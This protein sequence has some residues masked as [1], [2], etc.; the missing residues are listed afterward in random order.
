MAYVPSPAVEPA[1]GGEATVVTVVAGAKEADPSVKIILHHHLGRSNERMRPWLDNLIQRGVQFDII[2]MSCYA[3]AQEGDWK[4]NFADL[5][6]R[7]P[8]KGLLVV[9]YSARKRFINDLMFD[10]PDKKGLGTFIWEPTRH[11]ESL[12]D[13]DGKSA[14]GG[15][16]SNF[17]T[18]EGI[19]QGARLRTNS[20]L[21]TNIMTSAVNPANA[22]ENTN[23][24]EFIYR[25]FGTNENARADWR[26]RRFGGRY[27]VN[28]LMDLYP[29]MSRDY[30][31]DKTGQAR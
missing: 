4:N 26:K 2:G 5:A 9:E 25:S 13:K 19:A 30:G 28:E 6:K 18:D 15:Q 14:G 1:I 31:N 16:P 17:T 11:R 3:Q 22:P 10:T 29:Q 8:D 20:I 12:F 21:P 27:D 7:Y 23:S 24:P